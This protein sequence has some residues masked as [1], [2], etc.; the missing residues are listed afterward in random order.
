[1]NIF[2]KKIENVVSNATLLTENLIRRKLE[3]YQTGPLTIASNI[4]KLI[5]LHS[6][7]HIQNLFNLKCLY[8]NYNAYNISGIFVQ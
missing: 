4:Y 3:C 7:T 1:M 8:P 6:T 5:L 2:L